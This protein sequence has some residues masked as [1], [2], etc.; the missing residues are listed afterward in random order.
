MSAVTKHLLR[1]EAGQM[2]REVITNFRRIPHVNQIN[3]FGVIHLHYLTRHPSNQYRRYHLER[4]RV[5]LA[6]IIGNGAHPSPFFKLHVIYS[7]YPCAKLP[8]GL[9]FTPRRQSPPRND[10]NRGQLSRDP[11]TL[12]RRAGHV[13]TGNGHASFSGARRRYKS[14]ALHLSLWPEQWRLG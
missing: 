4:Q 3:P 5:P 10:R 14:G 9:V 11:A 1:S 7:P 6:Q 8:A 13:I 2:H 12:G